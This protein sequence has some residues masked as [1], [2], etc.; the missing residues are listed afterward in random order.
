MSRFAVLI[1]I[2]AVFVCGCERLSPCNSKE[3]LRIS[4]PDNLL[5]A[6]IVESDC[7][8]TTSF[9]ETVYIV[10]KSKGVSSDDVIFK[11]DHVSDLSLYWV[12]NKLL[13]IRYSK[14]RI[15]N[16]TNFWHSRDVD[17]FGYVVYILEK[18]KQ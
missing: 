2:V 10:P 14:A 16:F 18:Q 6:V 7:G 8:A 9:T 5:D 17:N 4:S 13:E 11:A 12:K 3:L 15:F 1:A